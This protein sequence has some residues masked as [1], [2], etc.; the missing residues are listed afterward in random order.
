[1]NIRNVVKGIA[2]VGLVATAFSFFPHFSRETIEATVKDVRG[3]AVI[4]DKGEFENTWS[5][6]ELKFSPY[7]LKEGQKYVLGV[8]GWEGPFNWKK[9]IIYI[10][11][12]AE[13]DF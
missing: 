13:Y 8:Y 12:I 5:A 2:A 1:M 3:E 11:E 4:T 10:E 6:W 9:N 7:K